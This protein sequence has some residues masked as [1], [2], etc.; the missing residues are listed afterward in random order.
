MSWGNLQ[1]LFEEGN[2]LSSLGNRVLREVCH[3]Y[4]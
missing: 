2:Q 1:P 3:A 4:S